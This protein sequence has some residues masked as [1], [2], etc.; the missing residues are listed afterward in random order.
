MFHW[1]QVANFW[2]WYWGMAFIKRP[3]GSILRIFGGQL[4]QCIRRCGDVCKSLLPA[5]DTIYKERSHQ[6]QSDGYAVS[7]LKHYNSSENNKVKYL[8]LC[9]HIHKHLLA[10]SWFTVKNALYLQCFTTNIRS[11]MEVKLGLQ[12]FIVWVLWSSI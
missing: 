1:I 5:E 10:C 12:H 2:L 6:Q 7:A 4:H 11:Y 3:R 9:F 8:L